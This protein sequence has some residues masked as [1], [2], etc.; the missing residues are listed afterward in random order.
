ME[1]KLID[2]DFEP[3][4]FE[5]RSAL[6]KNTAKSQWLGLAVILLCY[7]IPFFIYQYNEGRAVDDEKLKNVE[8]QLMDISELPIPPP[9]EIIPPPESIEIE[10]PEISTVKFIEP[11]AKPDEEVKEDYLPPTQEE[12]TKSNPG[13]ETREGKDSV[14]YDLRNVVV[15][16]PESGQKTTE[17]FS[18]SE[19]QPEFPGGASALNRFISENIVYPALAREAN[20]QGLVIVQ[21]VVEPDGS[22]TN[23]EVIRGLIT[24]LDKEAKRVT[25]LMPN[26][27]PGKQDGR[28]VRVRFT[29]PIRF[30]LI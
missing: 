13:L 30:V 7:L 10:K 9:V 20:I 26:W 27:K 21:F 24:D 16:A 2:T 22:I 17:I 14:L 8:L 28:A 18:Y 6:E 5:L 23:V 1:N 19:V 12:L 25:E 11:V 15:K 4:V 3:K 29:M